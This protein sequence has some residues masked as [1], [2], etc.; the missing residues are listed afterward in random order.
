MPL[1][2]YDRRLI[3]SL[4]KCLSLGTARHVV[5]R[6]PTCVE[7]IEHWIL[8]YSDGTSELVANTLTLDKWCCEVAPTCEGTPS[9]TVTIS[10]DPFF[11]DEASDQVVYTYVVENTGTQALTDITLTESFTGTSGSPTIISP[12]TLVSGDTNSNSILDVGETWTYETTKTWT[13]SN[14]D[15]INNVIDVTVNDCENNEITAQDDEDL[16]TVGAS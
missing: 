16:F 14:G 1:N 10:I 4:E 7:G 3:R 6:T 2:K 9:Y 11:V 5:D 12:L 13:W 15:T 8:D